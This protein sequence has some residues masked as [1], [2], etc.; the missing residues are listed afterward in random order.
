M[1]MDEA[2]RRRLVYVK[3][4]YMHGHDH[5]ANGTE[6]DRMIAIHHFDNAVEL[7]LK[8]VAT[9]CN[10]PLRV[11]TTFPDLWNEVNKK[12]ILP[13]KMEMFR[14]HSL[15][16]DIQHLGVSPI[17][18]TIVNRFDIYTDDFIRAILKDVFDLEYGDLFMSCL[19]EDEKVRGLLT[20]AEKALDMG[21]YKESVELVSAAFSLVYLQESG[22]LGIYSS[23]S[24]SSDIDD[25]SEIEFCLD[26]II[27]NISILALHIDFKNYS[28]FRKIA[29]KAYWRRDAF[30]FQ[31]PFFGKG[32]K[33]DAYT[34]EDAL[35][36]FN[37]VLDCLLKWHT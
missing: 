28:E 3:K 10:V 6:V 26:D 8:C 32:S 1:K 36:C 21:N 33:E 35:F 14:L 11:R 25:F 17:S 27:D 15:R 5:V 30:Y 12:F 13:K 4:L 24:P 16:S 37:F 7:L 18:L 9:V 19:I 29:P 22:K 31:E 34:K 20:K 2:T 23:F